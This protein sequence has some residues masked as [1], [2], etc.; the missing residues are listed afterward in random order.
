VRRHSQEPQEG[1]TCQEEVQVVDRRVIS[2]GVVGALDAYQQNHRWL[3]FPL[4]V[5][6]KFRDDQG[7]SILPH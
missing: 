3:G 7:V 5:I 4:A 1:E 6:Y 2:S